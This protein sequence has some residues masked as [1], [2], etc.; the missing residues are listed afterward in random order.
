MQTEF[1]RRQ[2]A[3]D[4][5]V[6]SQSAPVLFEPLSEGLGFH[7]FAEGLPYG[8]AQSVV[9]RATPEV[10]PG[11]PAAAPARGQSDTVLAGPVR[12]VLPE[13][14]RGEEAFDLELVLG[15]SPQK[16]VHPEGLSLGYVFARV[17]AYGFDLSLNALLEVACALGLSWSG[18]VSFEFLKS[19]SAL[20]SFGVVFILS[21]WVLIGVQE[22]TFQN[23]AGKALLGMTL[24]GGGRLRI[25]L[26][27]L[28]YPLA[29]G[30]GGLGVLSSLLNV[31]KACWHDRWT[32]V[33][34]IWKQ[35]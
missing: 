29:L 17:M 1:D 3:R 24:A 21:G 10:R 35:R 19:W 30:F 34:P 25:A 2:S 13:R 31:R 20:Q 18:Y 7:P 16:S 23:S 32:Q 22:V 5:S 26:R 14:E 11:I 12:W 27:S 33:Q 6:Q 8:G 15:E 4:P 28:L 9:G